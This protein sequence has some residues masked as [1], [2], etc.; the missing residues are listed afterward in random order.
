MVMVVMVVVVLVSV[1]SFVLILVTDSS[2]TRTLMG[3]GLSV[4]A[5]VQIDRHSPSAP[6]SH[7][8]IIVPAVTESSRR[9]EQ[10]PPRRRPFRGDVRVRGVRGGPGERGIR[11]GAPDLGHREQ[12]GEQKAERPEMLRCC[13]PGRRSSCRQGSRCNCSSCPSTQTSHNKLSSTRFCR[14]E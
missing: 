14:N 2:P 12:D 7:R 3:P 8:A 10:Q 1:T 13:F 4:A 9:L 5:A 6:C 11:S